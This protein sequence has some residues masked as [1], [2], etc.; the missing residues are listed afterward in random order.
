MAALGRGL[1]RL[2]YRNSSRAPWL[3]IGNN[4]VQGET[5]LT[6]YLSWKYLPFSGA[7]WGSRRS[8]HCGSRGIDP[9]LAILHLAVYSWTSQQKASICSSV[10]CGW[11]KIYLHCAL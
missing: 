4:L 1:Q 7:P 10:K 3:F 6:C 5:V 9:G 11:I 8:L 2:A